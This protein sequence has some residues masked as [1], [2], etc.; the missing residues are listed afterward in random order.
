MSKLVYRGVKY[1][2]HAAIEGAE[3]HGQFQKIY[4]GAPYQHAES[5]R[6]DHPVEHVYRGKRFMA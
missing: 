5:S 3:E 2:G 4:R 1:T 6:R